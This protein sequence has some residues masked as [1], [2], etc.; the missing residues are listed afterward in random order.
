MH[1]SG[2]SVRSEGEGRK[3]KGVRE[4]EREAEGKR[5]GERGWAAHR[6]KEAS[7]NEYRR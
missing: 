4:T 3:G 7:A 1:G 2:P 6:R 5:E